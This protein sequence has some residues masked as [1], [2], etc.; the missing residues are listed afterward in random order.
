MCC[1]R[2][3]EGGKLTRFAERVFFRRVQPQI[4]KLDREYKL[5]LDKI[6]EVALRSK[7]ISDIR[8]KLIQGEEIVRRLL[9]PRA[10]GVLSPRA[11]GVLTRRPGSEQHLQGVR[12]SCQGATGGIRPADDA[13]EV[14]GERGVHLVPQLDLGERACERGDLEGRELIGCATCRR[15]ST[16]AKRCPISRR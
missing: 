3:G 11:T 12:R 5:T 13:A 2:D 7:T 14:H 4:R 15:T 16:T 8:Q 9:P 10:T 6:N 1:V